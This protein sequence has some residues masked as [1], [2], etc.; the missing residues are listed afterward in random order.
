M[1]SFTAKNADRMSLEKILPLAMPLGLC[2]EPTNYCNFHC[3]QCPLSLPQFSEEVGGRLHLSFS[4]YEKIVADVKQMGRLNHLNLYGDGEPLLNKRICDM[5][6]LARRK[7]IAQYITVTT[8]ASLLTEETCQKL[9]DANLDY[10]RI[11]VY[12]TCKKE[13]CRITGVK[14]FSPAKIRSNVALMY[15]MKMRSRQKKPFIYAK[16]ID[17]YSKENEQFVESY[18]DITD[19]TNIESPMNWNGYDGLDLISHIDKE[20]KTNEHTTQGY[21][22]QKV[23]QDKIIC[24]TPFL[25]LNIKA[26]GDVTVC[27]VDWNKGTKVGNITKESL[28]DV[29]RGEKLR[30]FRKMHIDGRRSENVSCKNC[31]FLNCSP[32]NIDGLTQ[33]FYDK[34]ISGP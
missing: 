21:H 25:S 34:I 11:S 4:L 15:Q 22:K 5:V 13:F 12:S 7:D 1:K 33:D 17:T 9:I 20:K 18:K 30:E 10:L 28:G 3:I 19:E 14:Q 16:V 23:I 27:I 31:K 24:T 29:W 32:D 26:N 8:N 2:I 6:D